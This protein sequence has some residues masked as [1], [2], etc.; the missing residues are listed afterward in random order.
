[1][2]TLYSDN[3]KIENI[4]AVLFDKDGTFVDSDIYWGKLGEMRILEILKEYHLSDVLY[5]DLAAVIGLNSLSGKLIPNGPLAALSRDEVIGILADYLVKNNNIQTDTIEIAKIFERVHEKFI[6]NMFEYTFLLDGAKKLF[7]NLKQAK[8]KMAVVTSDS[9]LH[10]IETLKY[11]NIDKYFDFVVGCDSLPYIKSSGKPALFALDNLAVSSE[12]AIVVGD[13]PMDAQMAL[14]AGMK[15][16]VLVTTGQV[17]KED[18]MKFSS[19]I[20][21][22]LSEIK[23]E[24]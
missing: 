23:V 24:L 3:W 8:V 17:Q 7:E 13:A 9:Y 19:C 10:T 18:L 1:M 4:E 15:A 12:N 16:S 6:E 22:S 20:I 5:D 11:L 21:D 14:N 2:P